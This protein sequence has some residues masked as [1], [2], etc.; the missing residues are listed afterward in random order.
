MSGPIAAELHRRELGAGGGGGEQRARAQPPPLCG[1][2]LPGRPAGRAGRPHR[3]P[4]R[5]SCGS[6]S[7][8]STCFWA[9][10]SF[11]HHA[12]IVRKTLIPTILWLLTFYLWKMM[13]MYLQK[14]IRRI[15][16]IIIFLLA[17]WRSMTKIAGSGSINQR[18][19]SADPDPHQN[20][21]DP[22]YCFQGSRSPPSPP[23]VNCCT[24]PPSSSPGTSWGSSIS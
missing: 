12:K 9:S 19:G 1:Q 10:G 7:T 24:G 18:H 15:F 22:Q 13:Y 2:P 5:Q 17:S 14:V 23:S 4:P 21:M 8:G 6:R 11:Y 20:V 16:F 3:L